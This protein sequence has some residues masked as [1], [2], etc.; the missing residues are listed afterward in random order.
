MTLRNGDTFE[1]VITKKYR[2]DA[3][4]DLTDGTHTVVPRWAFKSVTEAA[5]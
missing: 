3:W 2:T 1:G 4:M 5:S